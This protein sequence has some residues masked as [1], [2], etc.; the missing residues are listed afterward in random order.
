[1][2]IREFPWLTFSFGLKFFFFLH[3]A[4][5]VS[6]S[7]RITKKI[8]LNNAVGSDYGGYLLCDKVK[9]CACVWVCQ[10]LVLSPFH[11]SALLYAK[12]MRSEETFRARRSSAQRGMRKCE[13][14]YRSQDLKPSTDR[15]W[16]PVQRVDQDKSGTTCQSSSG[17]LTFYI[18]LN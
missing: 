17:S 2:L 7:K 12:V 14:K 3:F 4:Y 18:H 10:P 6:Y 9:M 8:I 5:Y 15:L 16:N 13:G 11:L 1:M